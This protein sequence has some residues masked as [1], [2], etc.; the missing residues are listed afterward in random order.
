[1]VDIV[2]SKIFFI[3]LFAYFLTFGCS[4]KIRHQ[5]LSFF[6]DGVPPLEQKD[7]LKKMREPEAKQQE[8]ESEK[9]KV[10]VAEG[11]VHAPVADGE[12]TLCHDPE[13]SYRLTANS[14]S[15]CFD[16]H[17]DKKETPV[18]HTPVEEGLCTQCHNPHQSN[19]PSL[20]VK[21]GQDLCFQCHDKKHIQANEN[22]EEIEDIPCYVCHDP[23]GGDNKF[24][25]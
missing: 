15:L 5:A 25:L 14:E 4:K 11:S 24:F 19:H 2:G 23:H 21:K 16:C 17:E 12:C 8:F 7:D 10:V 13:D 20:L 6:F 22:H 1:M 9:A 18:V 3:F